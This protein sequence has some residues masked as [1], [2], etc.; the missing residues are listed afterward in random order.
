[1][2]WVRDSGWWAALASRSAGPAHVRP[3]GVTLARSALVIVMP[4]PA[5][6]RAPVFGA[7]VSWKFL[8]PE[9][10]GGPSSALGLHV[11]FPD[12]ASSATGLVALT[13]LRRICGRGEAAR[14]ALASF[15]VHVQVE[16]DPGGE[17]P[18]A[19]LATG[20][21]QPGAG[22]ATAPVTI[23]TEQAVARFDRAHPRQPLAVRY[24]A[25]GGQE[26]SYPYLLTTADPLTLAAASRF[27]DLLRSAYAASYV[28]YAGFR[29]GDGTAGRWP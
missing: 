11:E 25:E 9:S 15:A 24:P 20:R 6:A 7:S 2:A 16:P 27:G 14:A 19:S 12:P 28:R 5:A 29:S 4:R 10:A 13:E 17:T 23:T 22:A 8:L 1:A 3:S 26:L 21:P 18:L